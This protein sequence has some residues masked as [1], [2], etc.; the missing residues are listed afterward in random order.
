MNLKF[1]HDDKGNINGILGVTRNIDERKR[2]ELRLK[3][4]EERYRSIFDNSLDAILLTEPN[5]R[6]FS[7]NRAACEMF[8]MTE[9]EIIQG[10]RKGIVDIDNPALEKLLKGR[11]K[12][13]RVIGLLHFICSNG[14]RFPAEVSNSLFYDH[15]GNLRTSMIIRDISERRKAEEALRE[16]EERYRLIVENA[17]DGIEITQ[18]DHIIFCNTRFAEMLGYT[19]EELQ[20]IHFRDIFTE[21][22]NDELKERHEKR[23]KGEMLPGRYASTFYKKDGSIIDVEVTYEIIDYRGAPATFAIIRDITGFKRAQEELI[24]AKERAEESDRLKSAFLANMSHEIR[25]PMN[26]ILGFTDLLK[27]PKL[28]SREKEQYIRIIQK[29]GQRLLNTVN[30]IIEISKIET[31]QVDIV[32]KAVNFHYEIQDLCTFFGREAMKKGL[33]FHFDNHAP[34]ASSF[35]FL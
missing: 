30:D 17:N 4:S 15:E 33:E 10:G 34:S 14:K 3:E 29:S 2:A 20:N 23:K 32:K 35:I 1:T 18:N 28:D 11:E 9:A 21:K 26:G 6:I 24:R 27:N 22:A 12:N 5:E 16:S 7:A 13:G 31:G 25:T 19:I 8:G